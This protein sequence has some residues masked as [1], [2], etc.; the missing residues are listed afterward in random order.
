MTM[1]TDSETGPK[2]SEVRQATILKL[3][4]MLKAH[5]TKQHCYRSTDTALVYCTQLLHSLSTC[6]TYAR[7]HLPI[8]VLIS[9]TI[10]SEAC[11]PDAT[12]LPTPCWPG[13]ET[14][15]G[16]SDHHHTCGGHWPSQPLPC[17]QPGP[18]KRDHFLQSQPL[19]R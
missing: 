6:F 3:A 2:W 5:I 10:A 12:D 11:L 9:I 4:T 7:L 18:Q 19:L 16:S 15:P 13:S 14:M 1:Y 17:S 8:A